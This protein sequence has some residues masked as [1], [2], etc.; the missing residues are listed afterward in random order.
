MSEDE[1]DI[2]NRMALEDRDEAYMLDVAAPLAA[3]LSEGK[4]YVD[5]SQ[6]NDLVYFFGESIDDI[7]DALENGRFLLYGEIEVI[8][9]KPVTRMT[10]ADIQRKTGLSHG[11]IHRL[12]SKSGLVPVI[13]GRK[14]YYNLN[15]LAPF[16]AL[17]SSRR[18]E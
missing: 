15:D 11:T 7:D 2:I 6:F 3:K 17:S 10:P 13:E 14:K 18:E 1:S 8:R 9:V 12:L 4:N 5:A 16:L